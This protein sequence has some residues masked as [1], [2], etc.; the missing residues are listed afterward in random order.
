MSLFDHKPETVINIEGDLIINFGE[1]K[2]HHHHRHIKPILAF[3]ILIHNTN[4]NYMAIVTNLT[5]TSVAPVTLNMTV[6]DGPNGPQIAGVLSGLAYNVDATQDIAVVDPNDPLSVDIH[7]V[8]PQGGSTVTGTGNFVSTLLGSDGV[9][10]AFS[11]TVTGTLVL[12]NNVVVAVL[13]PVLA[14]NQ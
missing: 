14:F 1:E 13:N 5:L 6:T 12:V 8:A 3:N 4:F 10:P 7:S 2:P 9:T 11:G